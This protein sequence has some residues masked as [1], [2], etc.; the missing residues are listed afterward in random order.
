MTDGIP[1]IAY[2]VTDLESGD[3]IGEFDELTGGDLQI[4][5]VSYNLV[6]ES[7]GSTTKFI[8]GQTSY[9]PVVLSRALTPECEKIYDIFTEASEGKVNIQ[10][11]TIDLYQNLA[12][13]VSWDLFNIMI[14][15]ISGFEK[16]PYTENRIRK[17][18]ITIQ[19]ESIAMNYK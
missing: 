18:K 6:N 14:T 4:S 17:F 2:V 9:A 13:V 3:P 16:N 8:P 11:I 12:P 1:D 10:N 15:G 5:M 19:P 7:G